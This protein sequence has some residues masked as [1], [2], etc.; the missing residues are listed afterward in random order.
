[1]QRLWVLIPAALAAVALLWWSQRPAGESFV[2][3]V[4]EADNVRVGSRIGG[5]IEAVNV[6]E[7]QSVKRGDLLLT[8]EPF[9]LAE[10]LSE[11]RQRAAAAEAL[12]AKLHGGFRPEE[13]EQARARR[14]RLKARLDELTA[15]PRP[16]ELAILQDKLDV[17]EAELRRAEIEFQRVTE[18]VSQDRA[19]QLELDD[20]TRTRDTWAARAAEARN[21]LALARE[22]TRTEELSQARAALAEAEQALAMTQH[23]YRAEELAEADANVGAAKAAVAVIERQLSELRVL[24]PIDGVVEAVDLEPGDLIAPN[25]PV[26]S[27]LDPAEL[28]VR[29]YVPA[30]RLNLRNGDAVAVR[31]DGFPGRRFRAHVTFVSREAEFTPMNVQTPEERVKQVFRIKVTLDE[32]RDVLRAGMTADVLLEPAP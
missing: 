28:R 1:M 15:G 23:G 13:I 14:D 16:L 31:V 17:A 4:V 8:L 10:R 27:I 26:I 7:G 29:A 20:A 9:D 18:L 30:A 2:S 12:A 5:R 3:G 24:A 19:K 21:T 11:A 22:G 32:G 6:E 25:A